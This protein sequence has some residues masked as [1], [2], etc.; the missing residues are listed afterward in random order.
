MNDH[1][2]SM[3]GLG[4]T[5]NAYSQDPEAYAAIQGDRTRQ[6][7][8]Q[9]ML[10]RGMQQPQGQMVGRFYV[11]AS[12][13]QHAGNLAQAGLG[14]AGMSLADQKRL[15]LA[16]QIQDRQKQDVA[17]FQQSIAPRQVQAP[18]DATRAE[19]PDTWDVDALQGGPQVGTQRL[20][21]EP[22]AHVGTQVP[23]VDRGGMQPTSQTMPVEVPRSRED[24]KQAMFEGLLKY[25]NNPRLQ[26]AIKFMAQQQQAE[27][28]KKDDQEIRRE[29]IKETTATRM[30]TVANT[31]A[32]KEI[33]L[34][35]MER[36]GLRDE[37]AKRRHDNLL[38][39]MAKDRNELEK[40]R[41]KLDAE[42]K[43]EVATI[44]SS[45]RAEASAVKQQDKAEQART[46][47]DMALN[48]LSNTR[49]RARELLKHEGLGRITG[50]MGALP[51]VPGSKAADAEALLDQLKAMASVQM[52]NDLRQASKTGGAV[53]QV[54]ERE[55]GYLQ[56]AAARLQKTQ[57]TPAFKDAVQDYIASLDRVEKLVQEAYTRQFGGNGTAPAMTESV[58]PVRKYNPATGKIE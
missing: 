42:T 27:E 53:G 2:M 20:P 26:E 17:D 43:K 31:M 38:E 10:A 58:G 13:L 9:M 12:P 37:G 21:N 45:N 34:A 3:F 35:Q 36:E 51:N 50:L 15:E 30:A 24:V 47:V 56:N 55:W 44:Q 19:L 48:T 4:P 33:Q 46:N 14:V 49:D 22:R 54:T 16:K 29:A 57:G 23:I 18:I 39:S 5:A 7:I 28:L 11:P 6:L 52:I 1:L 8:A 40:W 32:M 41:A 25:G